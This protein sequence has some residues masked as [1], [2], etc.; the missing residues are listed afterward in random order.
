M[1]PRSA[2]STWDSPVLGIEQ[3][4]TL[5]KCSVT[6]LHPQPTTAGSNG[7]SIG[8]LLV[9]PF[10]S[11]VFC[12]DVRPYITY[13]QYPWRPEGGD[14]SLGTSVTDGCKQSSVYSTSETSH[15]PYVGPL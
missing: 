13:T 10:L 9:S 14:G 11:S 12:L 15:Q 2:C 4:L 6:E 7:R 8:D 1:N 5:G 3:G